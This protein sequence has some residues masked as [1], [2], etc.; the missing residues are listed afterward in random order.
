MAVSTS[1]KPLALN[2]Q[3][4][5]EAQVSNT[6]RSW[7]RFLR[8]RMAVIGLIILTALVLFSTVGTIFIPYERA[9]KTNVREKAQPPSWEHPFGTMANRG[10]DVLAR[11]VYGG[12][13]S[14]I[15]GVSAMLVSLAVGTA[16]GA[17]AGYYGGVL[18]SLLMRFT[19]AV[20]TIPRLF[21][22]L[23]MSKFL[24]GR[25]PEIVIGGREFSGGVVIII[26]IV[27]ITSWTTLARLVRAQILSLKQMEYVLAAEALGVPRVRILVQHILPNALASIIVSAT[28]GIA[29]AI[30]SEAYVSFL[31]LGV[32]PR[33]PTWGNMLQTGYSYISTAPWMWIFPGILIV[34]TTL[35]INFVGDGL[36]D[37]LDPRSKQGN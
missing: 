13:L 4:A 17:I 18:D 23:L 21:L 37:A 12:Q 1:A 9:T 8:H 27:G 34:L 10:E 29:G 2:T 25:M 5:P 26:F 20:L 11:A 3:P 30:L 31:G 32:D 28:L 16:V 22:L 24:G 36:R 7:R 19:E 35:S 6:Q 33:T 15:I 14:M